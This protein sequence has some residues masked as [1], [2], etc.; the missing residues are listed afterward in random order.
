MRAPSS[1][2]FDLALRAYQRKLWRAGQVR[3]FPAFARLFDRLRLALIFGSPE[4][5]LPKVSEVSHDD[6]DD[7]WHWKDEL[8]ARRIGF[9]GRLVHQKAT[10]VSMELLTAFLALHYAQG[11]CASYDE[12]HYY[13]RLTQRAKWICDALAQQGPCAS[14]RLRKSLGFKG[15]AGTRAYHQALLELQRR[16]KVV[17]AG[18]TGGGWKTRVI[19]LFERWVPAAV[20]K[21]AKALK[22]DE[23]RADIL[24]SFV[25]TAGAVPMGRVG[26]WLGWSGEELEVAAA[27]LERE[28]AI[29]RIHRPRRRDR[30]WLSAKGLDNV[31]T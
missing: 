1:S 9:L 13:G 10:L 20:E 5:P 18:L 28:G 29:L 26:R 3:S 21:R 30:V 17:T 15:P 8:Q 14:D 19:T 22:P 25:S 24:A 11:G 4:I 2:N 16:F 6:A 12:E 23:A 27:R 7:W 31:R